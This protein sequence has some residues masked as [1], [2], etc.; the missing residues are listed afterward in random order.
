MNHM[1]IITNRVSKRVIDYVHS[2]RHL[3]KEHACVG[4]VFHAV[5]RSVVGVVARLCVCVLLLCVSCRAGVWMMIFV[6]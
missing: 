1:L 6:T 5:S 4:W 3:I 2:S